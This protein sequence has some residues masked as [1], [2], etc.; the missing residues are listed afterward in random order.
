MAKPGLVVTEYDYKS[1]Q[2]SRV[3]DDFDLYKRGDTLIQHYDN[4]KVRCIRMTFTAP[5]G[6]LTA[7]DVIGM[8]YLPQGLILPNSIIRT[9]DFGSTTTLDVGFGAYTDNDGT[10]VPEN[11]DALIDGLDVSG[12]AVNATFLTAAETAA[13]DGYLVE[14]W[15]PVI[16][17][18]VGSTMQ[19]GAKIS[20][21]FFH[22]NGQ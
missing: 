16:A 1:D 3:A 17:T 10:I 22:V 11:G 14:G 7:G 9:T 6:G 21:Y 15:A 4:G 18:V 12:Q 2:L 20:L 8:G 19:A 5:S 13:Q